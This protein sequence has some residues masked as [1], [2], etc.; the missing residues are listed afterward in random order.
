M[1]GALVGSYPMVELLLLAVKDEETAPC[2]GDEGKVIG[3]EV[4]AHAVVAHG[5]HAHGHCGAVG[6]S[7]SA[8]R[9]GHAT[10]GR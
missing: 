4:M 7:R 6:V 8:L 3:T 9:Q 5:F 2:V 10:R 1:F